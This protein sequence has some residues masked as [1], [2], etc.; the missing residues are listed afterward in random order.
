MKP[1]ILLTLI[2]AVLV[3]FC[4][5]Q[6]EWA[7]VGAKWYYDYPGDI[8]WLNYTTI[9]SVGDTIIQGK[10]CRILQME[11]NFDSL[12]T[13]TYYDSNKVWVYEKGIFYKLY[14][15]D[16]IPGDTWEVID[17]F[18]RC[19]NDSI[20]TVR[21][22]SIGSVTIN[23]KVLKYIVVSFL[24]T[25]GFNWGF[26]CYG[27]VGEPNKII[28]KIGPLGYMF[29]Q[30]FCIIDYYYG[31]SLRCYS[32]SIFGSYQTG[33]VDSCTY[34]TTSV[35]EYNL[36]SNL[37]IFPNPLKDILYI[38]FPNKSIDC[39]IEIYN[40]YGQLIK[41]NIIEDNIKKINFSKYPK[42]IYILKLI[43]INKQF[44][45]KIIKL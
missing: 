4:F 7:P 25:G 23:D 11:R 24:P 20:S 26:E 43:S 30:N 10:N 32:D 16:A 15:F 37:Y 9:E 22:D 41:T 1:K 35:K 13:Y 33:I 12:R 29:P 31:C 28:E 6:N 5:G 44:V 40:I 34:T 39:L 36:D 19:Q 14:D 2:F 8:G 45:T 42:G 3:Q 18:H 27:D 17:I 21:V 38:E